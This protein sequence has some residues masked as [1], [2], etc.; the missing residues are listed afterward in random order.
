MNSELNPFELT[1]ENRWIL[2]YHDKNNRDWSKESFIKIMEIKNIGEFWQ[3]YNNINFTNNIYFLMKNDIFPLWETD[4]NKDGGVW[5]INFPRKCGQ[6]MWNLFSMLLVG[7]TMYNEEMNDDDINGISIRPKY[8]QCLIKIWTKNN[9]NL[10]YFCKKYN[11]NE[12]LTHTN[13]KL[14]EMKFEKHRDNNDNKIEK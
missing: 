4:E 10:D 1:F 2:Y 5:T 14:N 8:N 11:T 7:E 6:K 12:I 3:L 9:Q 13:M